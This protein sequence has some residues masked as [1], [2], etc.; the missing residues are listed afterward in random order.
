MKFNNLINSIQF[1]KF[2]NT[3]N[4]NRMIK[5]CSSLSLQYNRTLVEA[6]EPMFKV[7]VVRNPITKLL[8]GYKDK[9]KR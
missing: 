4:T 2:R 9:V 5:L 8:S 1:I 3:F 7:T 6:V